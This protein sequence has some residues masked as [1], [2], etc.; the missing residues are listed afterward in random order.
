[1]LQ[2]WFGLGFFAPKEI[3]AVDPA[4]LYGRQPVTIVELYQPRCG[5]RFG[6]GPCTATGT[7][8]CYQT[9]GSCKDRANIDLTGS[10]TWRFRKPDAGIMP[11]YAET[12]EDIRT[13]PIPML[14][15][16]STT[17]SAISAGAQRTGQSPL[18]IRATCTV[19]LQDAPWDDHVGD[20]SLALR[21]AV[22]GNFWAKWLARNGFYGGMTLT[23]Y[24][25]YRGQ[26]LSAM[27]R[28]DYVLDRV[29]GPNAQGQVTLT[30]ADPLRLAQVR[31]AQFPRATNIRLHSAIEA[32]TTDIRVFSAEADLSAD[33]GN[34]GSRRFVAMGRE[35]IRYTGWTLVSAGMYDLTGVARAQLGTVAEAQAANAVLQRV[36]RYEGLRR[37]EVAADLIDSH[38]RIPSGYRDAAQ[39][40]AEGNDYLVTQIS[41]ITIPAP[42]SVEETLGKLCLQGSFM[43]W[44]DERQRKIPLLANRPPKETPRAVT[45]RL[46]I[47]VGSA[48]TVDDPDAQ[49]SRV[50]V[51]YAPRNPFDLTRPEN[52][53]QLVTSV[54][55]DIEAP[56][57]AGAEKTLVI[58][59]DYIT[60]DADAFRLATRL[61]LR[62]RLIPK[63]LNLE[64]DAKDRS[65][66][67]GD[68]LAVTTAA[69]VD[70][71]GGMASTRWQVLRVDE[72]RPGSAF[73]VQLQS[74]F[75][76]GRFG[77]Y[78]PATATDDYATATAA[79]R[80]TGCYYADGTTGLMPGGDD[81]YFYQ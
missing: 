7:P 38:T 64:L 42:R 23:V 8:R 20:F 34:T 14:V 26:A 9:W 1:M 79:E 15:S 21:P 66:R 69:Y 25:G 2:Y 22:Q 31:E 40:N 18:G 24:E 73:R 28:R 60:G 35:I 77:F 70:V 48:E 29:Q 45:D 54:D 12:G 19:T 5:L 56:A 72:H 6:V 74:Y 46:N 57:A 17:S 16:V 58:Y 50:A 49:I 41:D 3:T 75:Y 4:T 63:F 53:R 37:W 62:Y 11:M 13:N 61:L 51:Y 10:I 43:I 80:E 52:F 65:I 68:V 30:G 71:E 32:G 55:G 81:P 67:I 78:M 47:L 33:Y 44:W 59:A 27:Q 76:I 36:G 39:W